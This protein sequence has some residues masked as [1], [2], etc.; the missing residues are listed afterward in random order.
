MGAAHSRRKPGAGGPT[1]A[2]LTLGGN[3]QP[4]RY[5]NFI[6]SLKS[7]TI[8]VVNAESADKGSNAESA[9]L[10]LLTALIKNIARF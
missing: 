6:L 8:K 2:K 9:E 3:H 4:P 7:K 1:C 5:G 10:K